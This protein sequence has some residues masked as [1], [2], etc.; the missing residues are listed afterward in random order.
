M[1][2]IKFIPIIHRE[3]MA[4]NSII[5]KIKKNSPI[6]V[7]SP[8]KKAAV[9]IIIKTIDD[10]PHI[11][12]VLRSNKLKEHAGQIA[13]PGGRVDEEDD[14]LIKTAIRETKEEIGID[15][16]KKDCIGRIDDFITNTSY[17]VICHV[18]R[19]PE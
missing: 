10:K 18:I 1:K 17:H 16:D 4:L 11:I 5:E 14:D 13:F 19:W 12:F 3:N 7:S 2:S 6:S 15:L 8:Y 9:A